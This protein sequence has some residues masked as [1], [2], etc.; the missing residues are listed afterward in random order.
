MAD[1]KEIN[2]ETK[3][4]ETG[5]Y[6]NNFSTAVTELFGLSKREELGGNEGMANE[7]TGTDGIQMQSSKSNIHVIPKYQGNPSVKKE[8]IIEEDTV[9]QGEIIAS[10]NISIAGS[11]RGDVTSQGD[12]ILS[13]K[14]YG[15]MKGNTI[16][17]RDGYVEGNINAKLGVNLIGDAIVVG[18][19]ECDNFLSESKVKGNVRTVNSVTL[20]KSAVLFGNIHA[21]T[22]NMQDGVILNGNIKIATDVSVEKIFQQAANDN[23]EEENKEDK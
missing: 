23:V 8:T 22:V 11:V 10:S 2:Q 19:V 14:I 20:K 13:G 1:N 3:A 6:F 15:N 5:G 18:D 17:I 9:I 7:N 21:K 12:I 16:T 4:E